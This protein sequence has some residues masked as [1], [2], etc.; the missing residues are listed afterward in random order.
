CSV[1]VVDGC[2]EISVPANVT[3]DSLPSN[4]AP[5]L[6]RAA[7][8]GDDWQ[9]VASFRSQVGAVEFTQGQGL[10]VTDGSNNPLI[11]A[12]TYS[13]NNFRALS[14]VRSGTTTHLNAAVPN[15]GLGSS[16]AHVRLV[17]VG[18]SWTY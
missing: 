14:Y 4:T 1:A 9:I 5:K 8:I 2:A 13:N 18:T 10:V 7:P 16:P 15:D 3:H 17:K 12:D 6:L 11:R